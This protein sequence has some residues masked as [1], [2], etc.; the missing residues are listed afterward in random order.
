MAK[1]TKKRNR[2]AEP[3]RRSHPLLAMANPRV[4]SAARACGCPNDPLQSYKSRV[5]KLKW[6]EFCAQ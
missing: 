3:L 1:M 4:S 5:G 2:R 6:R